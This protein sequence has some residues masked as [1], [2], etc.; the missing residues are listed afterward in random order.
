M[1]VNYSSSIFHFLL[2]LIYSYLTF[3]TFIISAMQ[4]VFVGYPSSNFQ[5]LHFQSMPIMNLYIFA[6][7]LSLMKDI[8]LIDI[9]Q[10]HLPVQ[11]ALNIEFIRPSIPTSYISNLYISYLQDIFSFS[12]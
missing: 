3:F 6:T 7:V 12:I 11:Y 1:F 5:Y 8:N 9:C 10:A 2:L 4:P